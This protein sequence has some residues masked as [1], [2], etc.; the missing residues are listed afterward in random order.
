MR[1]FTNA[2]NLVRSRNFS[3]RK[4]PM[5]WKLSVFHAD[6]FQWIKPFTEK[7]TCCS[8]RYIS[9]LTMRNSELG[10]KYS[11]LRLSTIFVDAPLNA[12]KSS[13]VSTPPASPTP[14][15]FTWLSWCF[16]IRSR[17]VYHFI[18]WK[19]LK[20]LT[21]RWWIEILSPC[22]LTSLRRPQIRFLG[23]IES[24]WK[25]MLFSR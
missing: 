21:L 6:L 13:F 8:T 11:C 22:K 25:K 19:N 3:C 9:C 2:P 15:L 12:L 7:C 17:R 16:Q 18:T 10:K 23:L 4:Q 5:H 1:A 20:Q 14:L 24:H